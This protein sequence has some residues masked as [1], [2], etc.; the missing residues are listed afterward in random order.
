M[1]SGDGMEAT[2]S[3]I[4]VESVKSNFSQNLEKLKSI[5]K[6]MKETITKQSMQKK[7][8]K[9]EPTLMPQKKNRRPL[10]KLQL[11]KVEEGISPKAVPSETKIGETRNENHSKIQMETKCFK[12]N[13]NVLVQHDSKNETLVAETREADSDNESGS[14][15]SS[16]TLSAVTVRRSDKAFMCETKASLTSLTSFTPSENNSVR[17]W[18]S[19]KLDEQKRK[20]LAQKKQDRKKQLEREKILEKERE[21]FK[22]WLA[23]KKKD[24]DKR[25]AEMERQQQLDQLME[26]EKEKRH[27]QN[28][29]N[30]QIWLKRKEEADIGN[31]N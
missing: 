9:H 19:R 28:Q 3:E 20:Q 27:L 11:S 22:I 29:I 6:S 12:V 15:T 13:E 21:N 31:P 26:L 16:S 24:E 17:Q 1:A 23:E 10:F 18:L 2:R 14:S 8:S 4:V 30:Y 7:I 5:N 25:K